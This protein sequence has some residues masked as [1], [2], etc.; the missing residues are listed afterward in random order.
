MDINITSE[1]VRQLATEIQTSVREIK[2]Q[3]DNLKQAIE[4][5]GQTNMDESYDNLRNYVKLSENVFGEH[6]DTFDTFITRLNNVADNIDRY[7]AKQG[8]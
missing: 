3:T 4:R 7:H 8:N 1:S 2:Q 5:L 6:A